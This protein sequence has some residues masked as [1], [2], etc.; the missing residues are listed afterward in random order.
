MLKRREEIKN[1]LEMEI[2]D[3]DKINL[4]GSIVTIENADLG[5]VV[6][7]VDSEVE[8]WLNKEEG[9]TVTELGNCWTDRDDENLGNFQPMNQ[10]DEEIVFYVNGAKGYKVEY[11]TEYLENELDEEDEVYEELM[12]LLGSDGDMYE[13]AEVIVNNNTEYIIDYIS[14]ARDEEGYIIVNLLVK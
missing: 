4:L 3:E 1:I 11:F 14:D 5:R 2:A 13:E 7:L 10:H 9:S 12:E 6:T 8:E